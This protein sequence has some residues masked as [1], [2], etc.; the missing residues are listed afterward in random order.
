MKEKEEIK[1]ELIKQFKSKNK[2]P[3]S[4]TGETARGSLTDILN[5][6]VENKNLN[7]KDIKDLI[8]FLKPTNVYLMNSII[9]G[10]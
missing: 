1:K 5:D 9:K 10:Y 7:D 3:L 6:I 4:L 8:L 2:N